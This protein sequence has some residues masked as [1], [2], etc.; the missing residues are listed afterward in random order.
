MPNKLFLEEYPLYRKLEVNIEP[1]RPGMYGYLGTTLEKLPKPAINMY[2]Y[3]CGSLQTFN[4]INNYWD[5]D[6]LSYASS[7]PIGHTFR[8]K[9]LCAGCGKKLILFYVEFNQIRKAS[10]KDE[11]I[12]YWIRKVGQ[13][14][15]WEVDIEKRLESILGSSSDL[16]KK[17]LI[18][19]SQGYGIGAYAYYRRIVEDITTSLLS[20]ISDLIEDEKM[21]ESYVLALEETKKAKNAEDK[22]KLVKDLLPASLR[23]QDINPLGI[24]YSSLSEGLHGK[25]DDDCLELADS[26]KKSLVFLIDQLLSQ[27]QSKKEFTESMRKLL[28][29]KK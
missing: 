12:S 17:G 16:Y 3:F 7:G 13:N 4:M 9:Y 27:K 1:V 26:I 18:S 25:T 22:I 28:D 8:L 15:P 6:K 19:E 14:P 11:A 20:S 21:K 2:C 10:G 5:D 24:I 29:K 23:P